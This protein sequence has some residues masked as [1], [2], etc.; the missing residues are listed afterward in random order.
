MKDPY[1]VAINVK[2]G[3]FWSFTEEV[4]HKR[5]EIPKVVL[6]ISLFPIELEARVK[7]MQRS[8]MKSFAGSESSSFKMSKAGC[9]TDGCRAKNLISKHLVE[10]RNNL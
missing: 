7:N 9:T 2:R 8:A 4:N 3:V 5:R 6:A 1:F 10:A